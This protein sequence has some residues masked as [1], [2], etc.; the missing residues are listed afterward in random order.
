MRTRCTVAFVVM[1]AMALGRIR[2][3]QAEAMRNL[4][5]SAC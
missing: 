3:N 2:T 5:K 4:L 1:L